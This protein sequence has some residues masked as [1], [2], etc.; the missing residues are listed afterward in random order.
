MLRGVC[1]IPRD[2]NPLI[3]I[4]DRGNERETPVTKLTVSECAHVLLQQG[5]YEC[6]SNSR[7]GQRPIR[8]T[9]M[10]ES[11]EN[12]PVYGGTCKTSAKNSAHRYTYRKPIPQGAESPY[13]QQMPVKRTL[14]KR[15]RGTDEVQCFADLL[16]HYWDLSTNG[17]HRSGLTG[18]LGRK[19]VIPKKR[20]RH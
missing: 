16:G 7:A 8:K 9:L 5:D 3:V 13:M 12:V 11:R 20:G 18:T 15:L 6:Y 19:V 10:L 14:C 1:V 17:P 4:D 2:K